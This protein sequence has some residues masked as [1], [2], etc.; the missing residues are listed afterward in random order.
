MVKV[1]S[2]L[3]AVATHLFKLF[4]SR[5]EDSRQVAYSDLIFNERDIAEGRYKNYLG[6]K[7]E[8][9]DQRG[10][11]QLEFLKSIGLNKN[12]TVLDI[13]CGPIRAGIHLIEFLN[14]GNYMG[15]DY[16]RSFIDIAQRI[17]DQQN[18][19][20]DKK[21]T[22]KVLDNFNFNNEHKNRD[23]LLL[24]SV[25]NHCSKIEKDFFFKNVKT[26]MKK[27]SCLI[28]SH[29]I[30]FNQDFLKLGPYVVSHSY[31]N[32][33]DL[34]DGLNIKDYG[35]EDEKEIFPIYQITLE[36]NSG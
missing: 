32:N 30:W 7:K 25:L 9:W 20:E 19:L 8:K 33:S 15:V 34:P 23:Y 27:S 6:G 13:G 5:I 16:S 28:I 4:K 17:I 1:K 31:Y 3:K 14:K 35:W 26:I 29:C 11:F 21:P 24:F 22:L 12:S 36:S 2:T 10:I 18:L